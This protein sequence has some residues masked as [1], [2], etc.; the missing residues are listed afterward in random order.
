MSELSKKTSFGGLVGAISGNGLATRPSRK[1]C[2]ELPDQDQDAIMSGQAT[3]PSRTPG[4]AGFAS[5][6]SGGGLST[7]P[8]RKAYDGLTEAER[9]LGKT[10]VVPSCF[11]AK[12][13]DAEVRRQPSSA[14][15]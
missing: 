11:A 7:R 6:I 14:V 3:L 13:E 1:A 8:S 12:R 2:E 15:I 5:A 4:S 9:V 10:S